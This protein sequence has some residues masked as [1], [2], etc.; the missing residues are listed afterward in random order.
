MALDVHQPPGSVA[1][2]KRRL[3]KGANK[4]LVNKS[5]IHLKIL[6]AIIS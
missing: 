3:L 1:K 2:P 6:N 5:P 4:T